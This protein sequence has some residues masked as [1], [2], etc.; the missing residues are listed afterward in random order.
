MPKKAVCPEI[1][2]AQ[3]VEKT[4]SGVA[5]ATAPVLVALQIAYIVAE[6]EVVA[7]VVEVTAALVS[8]V[9]VAVVVL[10]AVAAAVVGF[11]AEGM[12]YSSYL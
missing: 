2:D 6:Q 1:A 7:A 12:A 5:R 10:L 8:A 3:V 11:A 4:A 9:V